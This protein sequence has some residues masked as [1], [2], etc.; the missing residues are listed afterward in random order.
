MGGGSAVFSMCYK[1]LLGG[2]KTDR[3]FYLRIRVAV[4]VIPGK[5]ESI[6]GGLGSSLRFACWVSFAWIGRC[7]YR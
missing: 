3:L 1:G 2:V 6:Y 5:F 4:F 7:Q